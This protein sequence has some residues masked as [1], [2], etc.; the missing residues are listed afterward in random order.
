[1]SDDDLVLS[2][3]H[4]SVLVTDVTRSLEFYEAV[5]GLRVDQQRPNLGFDGAW[6]QVN[7]NQQIHL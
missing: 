1:M 2:I 4:A 6:L 7:A 5:L 3:H